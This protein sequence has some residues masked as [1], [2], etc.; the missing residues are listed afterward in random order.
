MAQSH[1]G[2]T[3]AA[4][5]FAGLLRCDRSKITFISTT[6]PQEGGFG[7]L[8]LSVVRACAFSKVFAGIV[9][10]AHMNGIEVAVKCPKMKIALNPRELK[11]FE[12]EITL[13]A[14]VSHY[15]AASISIKCHDVDPSS[16][17]SAPPLRA[18]HGLRHQPLRP[19]HRYG[20]GIRWKLVRQT[21]Q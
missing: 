8:Q 21:G 11:K 9:H 2:S 5:P 14:K 4:L 10:H 3:S 19:L 13:Q 6:P 17:G 16:S 20:V 7:E 18:D 1:A 15:L 12:K